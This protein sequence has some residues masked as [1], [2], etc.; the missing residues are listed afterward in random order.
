M[1]RKLKLY[2]LILKSFFIS[3]FY[4]RKKQKN[5]AILVSKKWKNK[6]SDDLLI[7]NELL[8]NH[9]NASLVTWDE[10]HKYS[11]YDLVIIRS[12]WGYEKKI[13]EFESLLQKL[14]KE[15]IQIQNGISI[16]KNNYDKEKQFALLDKY[17]IPHIKTTIIPK[18][19][20]D[21]ESFIKKSIKEKEFVIKPTISASGNNTYL[22]SEDEKRTNKISLNQIN[23]KFA[24][25]NKKISLMLQPFIKEID[26]GEISLIYIN[27]SYTH[28]ILRY[29]EVF[30]KKA[31]IVFIDNSKLDSK[32]FDVANQVLKI[33]EYQN[34]LFER[35]D[36][37]K[38]DNEY[39]V[40]EIEMVEPDLFIRQIKEEQLK[41]YILQKIVLAI[42][43]R[44]Q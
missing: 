4:S 22:I 8:H 16:L 6:V 14:V 25:L 39:Y 26:N 15:K 21:I 38:I 33:K 43:D 11:K 42:K 24:G 19:C 7:K 1:R 30:N 2:K 40:M 13:D 41:K 5:V 23:E 29:P 34:N 32:V 10:E 18:K 44:L 3:L 9:I 31:N 20:E 17:N 12:I 37:V 28:A 36:M 27:G 35:I